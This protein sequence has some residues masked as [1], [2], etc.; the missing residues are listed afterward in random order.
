MQE[1][2]RADNGLMPS[3]DFLADLTSVHFS[4]EDQVVLFMPDSGDVF[5]CSALSWL[6]LRNSP[7]D[8]SSELKELLIKL[9]VWAG[10]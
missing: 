2:P 10:N 5:R 9:G 7:P 4:G 3:V 1:I 6:E 8:V